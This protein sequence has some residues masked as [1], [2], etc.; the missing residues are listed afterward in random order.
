MKRCPECRRDYYDDSLLYCLDDGSALL[1]GPASQDGPATA[2]L[3]HEAD[4]PGVAATRAKIHTTDH[5]AILL[6][7]MS[8]RTRKGFNKRPLFAA[9]GLA[10]V[11]GGFFGYRYFSGSGSRQINSIAVM[12]FINDS[13]NADVDYLSDG[14]TE[15]LINGL[16]QIPG[17]SVKARSS[18][19]RYKGRDSDPRTIAKELGVDAI[20]NGRLVERGDQLTL[21]VELIDAGERVL[22]LTRWSGMGRDSDVPVELLEAIVFTVRD[23]LIVEGHV[24][25]DR[26]AALEALGMAE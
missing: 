24:F 21:N 11:L 23:G 10:V 25:P 13:D 17:L 3:P 22:C 12:P 1:E 9:L 26:A 19:F 18:V 15:T 20:L 14:M 8:D 6:S 5:T 16:S 7:G 2:I 4:S